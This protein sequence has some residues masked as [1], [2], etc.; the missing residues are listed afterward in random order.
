M[1]MRFSQVVVL[2][3]GAVGSISAQPIF[4]SYSP[5]YPQRFPTETSRSPV[6]LISSAE[7][8]PGPAKTAE[9]APACASGCATSAS[10]CSSCA[11][12][13][14]LCCEPCGPPGRFWVNAEFLYWGVR[15][16]SIPP[17]VTTSPAG[18][19]RSVAGA[20][21]VPTTTTVFGDRRLNDDFRPGF[22]VA[23]GLWLDD[24]HKFGIEGDFFFLGDSRQGF[25]AASSG[26]PILARP[27]FN[28]ATNAPD[29]ELV[30]FPNVVVGSVAVS[31]SS[32]LLGAGVNSR[33][34]LW[35]CDCVGRLDLIAGYRY[36]RLKDDLSIVEDLTSTGPVDSLPV[37]TRFQVLD[38]FRTENHFHGGRLGLAAELFRGRYFVDVTGSVALG[39]THEVVEISGATVITAPGGAPMTRAGGLLALPSNIGR[40]TSDRFAV[41][42]EIGARVG[43]NL[44]DHLRA[45]AGYD[46][47]Y[48]S[49]VVRAADQIDLGIN[50]TQLA[51]GTA[52]GAPRPA[53]IRHDTDF[54]AQG[55]SV[56]LEF[57]Y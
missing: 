46:F 13:T 56:G 24:C 49:R 53:F 35:C 42:P 30:A 16:N 9:P 5:Y 8:A 51:T 55:V 10:D 15:E 48:W 3:L 28:V 6:L 4:S 57:R 14:I 22:R 2:W 47:L 23:G 25:T 38:R 27:F 54:W 44:T 37:G 11:P 41:V 33:C 19:P 18:T 36:L 20:L 52:V 45:Y 31:S 26:F 7:T 50:P 32:S 40:Y 12:C 21:G 29:A 17:L 39:V 1:L 43:V 34:N